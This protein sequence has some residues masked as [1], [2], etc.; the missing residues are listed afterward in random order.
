MIRRFTPNLTRLENRLALDASTGLVVAAAAVAIP[1]VPPVPID[2]APGPNLIDGATQFG[3]LHPL[4]PTDPMLEP[5]PGMPTI[6][7]PSMTPVQHTVDPEIPGPLAVPPLTVDMANKV[8]IF[9]GDPLM[10]PAP[11]M[12][13]ILQ[14]PATNPIT[15]PST[16]PTTA[17]PDGAGA[18]AGAVIGTTAIVRTSLSPTMGLSFALGSFSPVGS[19]SP[20]N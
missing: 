11:S 7:V 10:T 14:P 6:Q 13:P 4:V 8:Q 18:G 16:P 12:P 2:M 3:P 15:K 1:P 17:A 20:L 19:T 9:P 5:G